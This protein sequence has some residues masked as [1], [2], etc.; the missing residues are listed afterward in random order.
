VSWDDCATW[1]SR[2]NLALPTEAQWENACRA[3]TPTAWWCGDE[4]KKLEN[5]ANIADAFCKANG[6]P[7]SWSYTE[8]VNDGWLAHAPVGSLAPNAFGL[9][10]VHGN[11]WEWCQDSWC[12]YAADAATDPVS[13]EAGSR[14]YRGGSWVNDASSARS[15][16][17]LSGDPSIRSSNI[18]VRPARR[19]TPE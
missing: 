17:R 3:G 10:D 6:A 7:G 14:V 15:A 8:E 12:R 18:G 5:V 4:V 16:A 9:H 11:V 2:H 19:V 13:G 1:L